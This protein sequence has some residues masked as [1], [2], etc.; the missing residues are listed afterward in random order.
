MTRL[1]LFI[2]SL[3]V[4]CL[5]FVASG[6]LAVS[7]FAAP[8]LY[9]DPASLSP[10]KNSDVNVNLKIDVENQSAFG[11][12]AVV[13]FPAS[14]ITIKSVSK[15]DFFSDFSYAPSSGKLEIHGYFATL[16]QTKT[17]SGTFATITFS[18][19]KDSGTGAISLACAGDGSDTD[20]INS[21]GTNI[22]T[23]SSVNQLNLT[24]SPTSSSTG[25]TT[26]STTGTSSSDNGPTNACGG[27]CGSNYNCNSGLFCYSGFC[28]NP[29]CRND[30]TCTCKATPTPTPSP[31]PKP[32]VTPT[33]TTKPLVSP[34]PPV[35]K[36]V[37][38]SPNTPVLSTPEAVPQEAQGMSNA[39]RAAIVIGFIIAAIVI[40]LIAAKV[41]KKKN[42][43]PPY[44]A[45]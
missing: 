19:S 12:D 33:P 42:L 7:A 23:C 20:I 40:L 41:F 44:I 8:R 17:G 43:P 4:S 1:K 39:G 37:I 36:L 18:T 2:K 28:R 29:D 14:D 45:T 26:N 38:A 24:Y 27:T 6:I 21:N 11:A 10:S 32:K 35:V 31:K 5:F 3:L 25:S 16:F 15:G 22:L 13:N 9:F 34:T 30:L